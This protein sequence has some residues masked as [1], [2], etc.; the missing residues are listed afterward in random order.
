M[1]SNDE[2]KLITTWSENI[3]K[4]INITKNNRNYN[5]NYKNVSCKISQPTE[6]YQFFMISPNDNNDRD[7]Y[8]DINKYCIEKNITSK[9]I[10]S[11]F[12][13]IIKYID[14][15]ESQE[16]V[17]KIEL[18]DT[19]INIDNFN[20]LYHT[21]K[22]RLNKLIG[23]SKSTTQS[24]SNLKNIYDNKTIA[25]LIIGEYM[26][27]WE[28]VNQQKYI[29]LDL[30]NDNLFIWVIKI[31]FD[32]K[33]CKLSEDF[34]KI[35]NKTG[36]DYITCE[37]YFDNELYPNYPPA[38]KI[39]DN[40]SH[41]LSHRISNS[42]MT[43]LSYWTPTRNTIEI[44]DRIVKILTKF[45]RLEKQN[46]MGEHNPSIILL[47]SHLSKLSSYIDIVK[48][49]EIDTD[50]DYIKFNILSE[51][52]NNIENDTKKQN[53]KYWKSGI[54]YGHDGTSQW[55][56][57]EYLELQNKK[58]KNILDII[59]NILNTLRILCDNKHT[60]DMISDDII[61]IISN[62]LLFQYIKQQFKCST[63]LDIDNNSHVFSLYLKIIK[64]LLC[65]KTMNIFYSNIKTDSL[66]DILRNTYVMIQNSQKLNT[67]NNNTFFN[68][69]ISEMDKN[70]IPI[71]IEFIDNNTCVSDNKSTN[72]KNIDVNH[73]YN[74]DANHKYADTLTPLRFNYAN[75]KNSF[76]KEYLDLFNVAKH[77]N[78]GKQLKRLSIELPSLVPIG[79]LPINYESSIF[80]RVDDTSPSLIRA[81]ITGPKDTPYDS[82]CFIFD[83]YADQAYPT[84]PPCVLFK[85][86]GGH[87]LNPNLY[88]EGKVCLSI[89]GTWDSPHSCEKWN[90]KTSSLLQI[91]VSIQS[92]ILIE[93]PYFNE[94]GFEK[95]MNTSDGKLKSK[96]YNDN[97]ICETL[98]ST[99]LDLIQNPNIYP[100][101][102]DVI[103]NHFKLKKDYITN[104][105]IKIGNELPDTKLSKFN[106]LSANIIKCL[107]K[108]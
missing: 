52:S 100:E 61:N 90:S 30:K 91:L 17:K 23:S 79:Q 80:I 104:M 38:I 87:R 47:E 60:K 70:I 19:D 102:E 37:I 21:I 44:V 32:N 14:K 9:K 27:L 29:K 10:T 5:L 63:L 82:G 94:P 36:I 33:K 6:D 42:K 99:I 55:N 66:Y 28:W 88:A 64:I 46:I 1:N 96:H 105:L 31:F 77:D 86:S 48:D 4:K 20:I 15:Y 2:W 107:D 69:F 8:D 65:P 45:G 72:C 76:S 93:N 26:N 34:K 53:K 83:I 67:S 103:M 43:Q 51:N 57:N 11:I 106:G 12:N 108:L 50:V 16:P 13:K 74:I 41:S 89:L 68:D 81:L 75:I 59:T 95:T 7:W 39:L 58:N 25:N 85:N 97:I 101:F 35:K 62:S 18:L 56:I 78:W 92:Q 3:D 22:S 24:Q 40:L 54:G 71:C 98:K 73:K 84:K 49:D